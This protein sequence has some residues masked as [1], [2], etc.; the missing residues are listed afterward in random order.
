MF[1]Y[2]RATPTEECMEKAQIKSV[3]ILRVP[4]FHPNLYLARLDLDVEHFT[5]VWII[6]RNF[7]STSF[8]S[9]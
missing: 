8:R 9:P 5:P 2:T 7:N 4:A 1:R 3:V 6:D